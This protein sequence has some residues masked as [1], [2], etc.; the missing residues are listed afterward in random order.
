[1]S[2]VPSGDYVTNLVPDDFWLITGLGRLRMPDS[3]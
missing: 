2:V 1:M 3:S